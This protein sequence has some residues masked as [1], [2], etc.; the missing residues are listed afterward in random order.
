MVRDIGEIVKENHVIETEY[1]ET[2]FVAVPK[3]ASSL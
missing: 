2:L 1:M 3:F